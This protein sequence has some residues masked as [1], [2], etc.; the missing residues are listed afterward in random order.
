MNNL[1]KK[2]MNKTE[3]LLLKS[4]SYRAYRQDQKCRQQEQLERR[5]WLFRLIKSGALNQTSMSQITE[6]LRMHF[7]S[8]RH[9]SLTEEDFNTLIQSLVERDLIRLDA[10]SVLQLVY[11]TE[12]GVN[13]EIKETPHDLS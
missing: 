1:Y 6:S 9:T 3:S 10:R 7:Q 4:K 12:K 8:Y 13:T 5:Y 2:L 11:L